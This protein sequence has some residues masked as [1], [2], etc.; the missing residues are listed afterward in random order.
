ML[1]KLYVI[2]VE[3]PCKAVV[4]YYGNYKWRGAARRP[5]VHRECY[6][7]R[8]LFTQQ[9]VVYPENN[10]PESPLIYI[11]VKQGGKTQMFFM[12]K[13]NEPYSLFLDA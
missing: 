5:C 3:T 8:L 6:A 1:F 7:R 13:Q 4:V 10:V 12:H 9:S 2:K 11:R